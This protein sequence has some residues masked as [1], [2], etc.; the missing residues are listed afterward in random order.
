MMSVRFCP[1]YLLLLLPFLG[2]PAGA[3]PVR[4]S[5]GALAATLDPA[6]GGAL[7]ALEYTAR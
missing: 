3:G 5:A 2:T 4:V 6:R 1:L 7:T